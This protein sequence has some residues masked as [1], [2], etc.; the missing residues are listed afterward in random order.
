MSRLKQALARSSP[1]AAGAITAHYANRLDASAQSSFERIV[2]RVE[3]ML[4]AAQAGLAGM[5]AAEV[6]AQ[7]PQLP[8]P[9][10]TRVYETPVTQVIE[11]REVVER[12]VERQDLVPVRVKRGK[13]GRIE[14]IV[15]GDQE[16]LVQRD[17]D[18]LITGLRGF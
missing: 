9:Q 11:T 16:Y 10:I 13:D 3:Q 6:A 4:A 5:V 2:P 15:R 14:R 18:G 7:M 8:A 1:A 17:A 12:V